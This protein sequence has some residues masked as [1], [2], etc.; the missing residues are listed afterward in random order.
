MADLFGYLITGLATLLSSFFEFLT[1]PISW[2]LT[3]MDGIFYFIYKLVTIL[4]HVLAVFMAFFQLI[5]AVSAGLIR[6][7]TGFLAWSGKPLS[8]TVGA[9]GLSVFSTMLSPLGLSTV[10]PMILLALDIFLTAYVVMWLV[11]GRK[12]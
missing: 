7:V 2:F 12:T 8:S 9:D 1:K 10:L 3:F 5:F 6:T 4:V 11:G